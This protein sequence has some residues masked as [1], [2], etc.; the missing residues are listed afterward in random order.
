[1]ADFEYTYIQNNSNPMAY[2]HQRGK[3]S[4]PFIDSEEPESF[5]LCD[6]EPSD[7]CNDET[8]KILAL[9]DP[10]FTN[11]ERNDYL[12]VLY[13]V[14]LNN[15]IN[16]A[17]EK[18][19]VSAWT[20]KVADLSAT[21]LGTYYA[22]SV[23]QTGFN[24]IK[25]TG[26][27]LEWRNVL[28]N[29]GVGLY[30]IKSTGTFLGNSWSDCTH[31]YCLKQ[32]STDAANQTVRFEWKNNGILSYANPQTGAFKRINY[33][34]IDW[35]DMI[36][37]DG[38]FGHPEDQQEVV[39]L[40]YIKGNHLE[41]ERISDKTNYNYKFYSGYYP[42]WVHYLL[43]DIAFKS[44]SLQVTDYNKLGKHNFVRKAIIKL[45][46]GYT[47]DYT[48]V[49][50]K[51]YKVQVNFRDKLDDLGY[52]KNCSVQGDYCAPVTIKDQNGNVITT[53]PSGSTYVLP[54]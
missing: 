46:D 35:Q 29:Y 2:R 43:K 24:A 48:N 28:I 3:I 5:N 7:F 18:W 39:D 17:L 21:A 9:A 50:Q 10:I 32:Y 20:T 27:R 36:R 22:P 40:S 25:F 15:T 30:R 19:E 14:T 4:A 38:Y 52:S 33:Q 31:I 47:P 37:L 51:K 8:F 12:S 1:M 6:E 49:Y 13:T 53:K 34:N 26:Y 11:P 41:V 44:N 16:F 42:D 45:P 23:L 54:S